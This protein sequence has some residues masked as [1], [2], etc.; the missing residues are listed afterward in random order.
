MS[1]PNPPS[2]SVS[3]QMQNPRTKEPP[4][5]VMICNYRARPQRLHSALCVQKASKLTN[6]PGQEMELLFPLDRYEH[7]EKHRDFQHN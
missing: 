3:L 2:L 5:K 7:W 4:C 1:L 6:G